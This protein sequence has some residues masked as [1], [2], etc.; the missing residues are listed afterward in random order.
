MAGIEGL[1]Q[2]IHTCLSFSTS[3]PLLRHIHDMQTHFHD[4]CVHLKITTDQTK[5]KTENIINLC[6]CGAGLSSV[7]VTDNLSA[8]EMFPFVSTQAFVKK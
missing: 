7:V 5:T 8:L 2:G 1:P 6:P 4:L 3:Q